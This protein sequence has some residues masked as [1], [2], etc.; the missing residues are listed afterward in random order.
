[1]E[2]EAILEGAMT[3]ETA[4]TVDDCIVN[5]PPEVA[6][7][8]ISLHQMVRTAAPGAVESI[9]YGMPTFWQGKVLLHFGAF[10]DHIGIY[11]PVREAGLADRIAPDRG[12]KGNLRLPLDQPIPDDLIADI[13]KARLPPSP[14]RAPR[15]RG[16]NQW[17][18]EVL[19]FVSASAP[20]R[21]SSP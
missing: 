3:G 7:V 16:R 8:L 17:P 20:P 21:R 5:V 6:D 1:M 19:G 4:R 9:S 18:G 14:R 2:R 11:P 10:K 13:V 15:R 12:E